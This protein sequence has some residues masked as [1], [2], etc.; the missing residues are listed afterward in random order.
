MSVT[1]AFSGA[2]TSNKSRKQKRTMTQ[3]HADLVSLGYEGVQ[4]W[5]GNCAGMVL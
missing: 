3:L 5:D 1:Q 2:A 4:S